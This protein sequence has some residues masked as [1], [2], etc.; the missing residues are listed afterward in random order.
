MK[1]EIL[2][3]QLM[4]KDLV[5]ENNKS[6]PSMK[7]ILYEKMQFQDCFGNDIFHKVGE[8]TVT[9]GGAA[10]SLEHL[11]GVSANWKPKT[12]NDIMGIDT[13]TT[14]SN[15]V[16]SERIALFGVGR[17]G[18]GLSFGSVLDTDVKLNTLPGSGLIPLRVCDALTGDDAN[19]YYLSRSNGDGTTSW[20]LKEFPVP[21]EIKSCWKDS[22]DDEEDGTEINSEVA[23]SVRTEG[24]QTFADIILDFSVKD[25]REYYQTLP[26][27]DNAYYNSIGLFTGVKRTLAG[28]SFYSDIRLFSYLN[29]ENKSVKI[30]TKSEYLYRVLALV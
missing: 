25:V 17:D 29:F 21:I 7:G 15:I 16:Q 5:V 23:G 14:G 12:I 13:V 19:R 11:T 27:M 26:N 9:I 6:V 8:N 2:R 3:D 18:C 4:L 20:Y 10:T 1:R 28:K 30:K 22:A 24:I